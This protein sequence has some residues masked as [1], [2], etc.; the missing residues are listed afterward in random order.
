MGKINLNATTVLDCMMTL[1]RKLLLGFCREQTE[2][3]NRDGQQ[4]G[5]VWRRK[6]RLM[7]VTHLEAVDLELYRLQYGFGHFM[8]LWG[9]LLRLALIALL[10]HGGR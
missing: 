5:V 8:A 3:R 2:L 9:A 4:Q 7:H 10:L 1:R 6:R